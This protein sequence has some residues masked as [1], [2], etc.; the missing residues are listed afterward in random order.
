M[1]RKLLLSIFLPLFG[2]SL[3]F[4]QSANIAMPYKGIADKFFSDIAYTDKDS[5]LESA[6]ALNI[7]I[8]E[9]GITLLK[10]KDNLLP[11]KNTLNKLSVFGKSSVNI[12]LGGG[13]AGA[14][15]VT[16]GITKID[17]H[18][19][20]TDAGFVLNDELTNF[21]KSLEKSGPFKKSGSSSWGVDNTIVYETD[22]AYYTQDIIDTFKNYNDAA[23]VVISREGSEGSDFCSYDVRDNQTGAPATTKHLL[24][25]SNDETDM[26][27]LV[28][29]HFSRI[30]VLIN[31]GNIFQCDRFESDDKIGAVLWIGNPGANGCAAIG[32]IL[33]GMVN[34]SGRTVDT[35]PRDFTKDPTFKNF[36]DNSQSNIDP[37][38]KVA[39][40]ADTMFN[41][42][43][44]PLR[45]LGTYSL[46]DGNPEWLN[47]VKKVVEGGLNKAR[48][49][50]YISYEEGIYLDYRY[51]ETRYA[52]LEKAK[53]G[54]G[55]SWYAG[56]E[57][58][59]YPFGY[60][61]NYT[62][63]KQEIIDSNKIQATKKSKARFEVTVRVTNT[64][65]VAGKDV[66]Q[67]YFKAP[68][69][70]G[71][72]EKPYEVLCAFEKT[73]LLTPSQSQ[74]IKLSFYLQDMA[75]Y[76]YND[77][78]KNMFS[79][80]ELEKGEYIISLNKNAH[81]VYDSFSFLLNSGIKYSNDRFT[82]HEVRNHFTSSGQFNSLPGERDVEF[83]NFS[84][85]DFL[86][87]FPKAPTFADRTL[88]EN[89]VPNDFLNHPF[90]IFDVE[91]DYAG[92]YFA[93]QAKKNKQDFVTNDWKQHNSTMSLAKEESIRL[94]DMSSVAYNDKKWDQFINEF[95]YDELLNF[96]SGTS[97]TSRALERIDKPNFDISDGASF[98]RLMWWCGAPIVAATFNMDLA[99]QQGECIGIE[100][101]IS[102]VYGWI[103]P[104]VNL[105]RSPFGG[106]NFENY[107]ADPFLSGRMAAK[108]V[109]A[110][111]DKGVN[112]YVGRF[113]LNEQE[114]NREG[115]ITY[116]NEQALR[117][118]YLKPFQMCVQEG[119]TNAV[120][121]SYNRIGLQETAAC[122]QLLTEILR[123]EWG[124]KG[125]VMSDYTHVGNASFDHRMYENI[126]C[127]L[128]AGC[129]EQLDL[130]SY[131]PYID[132][133]WDS[134]A[135]DGKGAP[136]YVNNQ[137]KYEAYTWWYAVREGAKGI[138]YATAKNGAMNRDFVVSA[139]SV[140]FVGA[141]DGLYQGYIN[142]DIDIKI[143]LPDTLKVGQ[144]YKGKEIKLMILSLDPVTPLPVGMALEGGAIKGRLTEGFNGFVHVLIN[145]TLEGETEV[146][147]LGS[148]LD[149]F[150]APYADSYDLSDFGQSIDG[151]GCFN[152]IRI[153]TMSG[154]ALLVAG[155]S[156]LL[157]KKKEKAA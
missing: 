100:A 55:Y 134:T 111:T 37:L 71:G 108:V 65:N 20:L 92:D 46:N 22:A 9:E 79:N 127:R 60:G 61:L 147:V 135:F 73:D 39:Y 67:L 132:A 15:Y 112:C 146:E 41:P 10:N 93:R 68:Y 83:S 32:K 91:N 123:E 23:V 119:K 6:Q 102:G 81:E 107:S 120:L 85:K 124:F 137:V 70:K 131:I 69:T 113:A 117:E 58:V 5:Y 103:G 11:L 66:A 45:S 19:S 98:F 118:L 155:I 141:V 74:E 143:K 8:A 57:G 13:G 29:V 25:L 114:T 144:M 116:V 133:V 87:T 56:I 51:Y 130:N 95:T 149:L 43:G 48:P 86:S 31:S 44:S 47:E 16:S 128:I 90:S 139:E 89:N 109:G 99:K 14:G 7:K 28:E 4:Q 154:I 105:H 36:G 136:V 54:S 53:V 1:Y 97:F 49:G 138:L 104:N 156:I 152:G 17:T 88:K 50:A 63:F 27:D 122:Y 78:N 129:S 21:Y 33:K 40:P 115:V 42:D 34:P 77:A 101:H 26:L 142:Q 12:A 59:V 96:V 153:L 84:R 75:V 110:A 64:G 62:T 35:W 2:M 125:M 80:Y 126:N 30:I 145:L 82:D 24:Q 148:S 106:R 52:E 151:I 150:I 76:D 94:K 3:V 157:F 140:E 121:T 38:T 18:K 72:L